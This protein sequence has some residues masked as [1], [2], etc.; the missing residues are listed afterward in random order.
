MEHRCFCKILIQHIIFFN[1]SPTLSTFTKGKILDTIY[2]H[3][4]PVRCSS[5]NMVKKHAEVVAFPLR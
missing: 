4:I 5:G 1:K 3:K 2:G